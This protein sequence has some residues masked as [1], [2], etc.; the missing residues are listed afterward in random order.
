MVGESRDDDIKKLTLNSCGVEW[1]DADGTWDTALL[2]DSHWGNKEL[3]ED[4]PAEY[5]CVGSDESL[6]FGLYMVLASIQVIFIIG[7]FV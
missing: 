6:I 5:A 3:K 4:S 2:L 7:L 1:N